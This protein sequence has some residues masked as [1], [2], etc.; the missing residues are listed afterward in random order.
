[1]ASGAI[2]QI[3]VASE[4]NFQYSGSNA[5]PGTNQLIK[6]Y[7]ADKTIDLNSRVQRNN[8]YEKAYT[9]QGEDLRK[10]Y[11]YLHPNVKFNKSKKN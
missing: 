10:Y 1:M 5:N 8:L 9:K 4:I 2:N 6:D 3:K 7:T 11:Q